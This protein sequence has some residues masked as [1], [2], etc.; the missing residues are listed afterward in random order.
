MEYKLYDYRIGE[1]TII[2]NDWEL[3]CDILAVSPEMGLLA[4]EFEG[5]SNYSLVWYGSA[6]EN[7]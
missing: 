2:Q 4:Q 1:Y 5:S 3:V 7:A 6:I